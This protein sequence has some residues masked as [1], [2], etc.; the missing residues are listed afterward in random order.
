MKKLV[1]LLVGF[2]FSTA[3]MA[4]VVPS[5]LAEGVKMLSYEKNKSALNFFKEAYDK[6]PADGETIF[7]Y[8]QAIL[9]QNYNGISTPESIQKAKELYQKWYNAMPEEEKNEASSEA[10]GKNAGET[11]FFVVQTFMNKFNAA[12]EELKDK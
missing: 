10:L 2:V 3:L 6:N 8:G 9:A 1:F 12:A 5:P 7:W 11:T 4:Q